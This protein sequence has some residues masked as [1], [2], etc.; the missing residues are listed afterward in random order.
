MTRKRA[1][2]AGALVVLVVAA[3]LPL[4]F[5]TPAAAQDSTDDSSFFDSLVTSDDGEPGFVQRLLLEVTSLGSRTVDQYTSS[6]GNA[7]QYAEDTTETFN[8]NNESI[9]TYVSERL[10]VVTDYDVYAVHFHD[11]AGNNVT[12]YVVS[13]AN[14]DAGS[15]ENARM[16]T[17][18]EFEN[19]NRSTDYE[20]E[21]DWF[22]SKHANSELEHFVDEYATTGD[23][24]STGYKASRIAKYGSGINSGLWNSSGGD[25]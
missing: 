13:T 20:V 12:R 4:G 3:S 14:T 22:V 2:T 7:T 23:D 18:S 6:P 25:S 16:L 19:A 21:L 8:A 1:L 24:L 10:T 9:E 17:P 5:T 11:R 15:Y